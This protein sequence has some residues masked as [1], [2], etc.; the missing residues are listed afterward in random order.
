MRMR[1]LV[2]GALP[3]NAGNNMN[4][5]TN[6]LLNL[7]LFPIVIAMIVLSFIF[8]PKDTWGKMMEEVQE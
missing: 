5:I 1:G 6:F 2:L 4:K 7:V 3:L 8:D